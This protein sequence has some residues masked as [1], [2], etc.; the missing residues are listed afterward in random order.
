MKISVL[1]WILKSMFSQIETLLTNNSNS[2]ITHANT[3]AFTNRQKA[4]HGED[5]FWGVSTFL[6]HQ[7]LNT[8][9]WKLLGVSEKTLEK[10]FENKYNRN[11][12]IRNLQEAKELPL[13]KK[14]SQALTKHIKKT[15]KTLDLDILFFVSFHDLS[16]QFTKHLYDHQ[17]D[18]ETIVENYKKLNKNPLIIKM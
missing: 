13:S 11:T 8:I 18:A 6:K 15:T 17:I 2:C 7:D 5:L 16:N 1:Y 14:I 10:Y 9:F 3:L 12:I 4:I